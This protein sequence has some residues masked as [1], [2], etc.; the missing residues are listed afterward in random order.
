MDLPNDRY[1]DQLHRLK[2]EDEL[3]S[4]IAN[5]D[6]FFKK[7]FKRYYDIENI[8]QWKN[9]LLDIIK[10][11]FTTFP[12][13]PILGI[14]LI[15]DFDTNLYSSTNL[16]NT[17]M[18]DDTRKMELGKQVDYQINASSG[19]IRF[20]YYYKEEPMMNIIS[21]GVFMNEWMRYKNDIGFIQENVISQ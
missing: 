3:N 17:M 14:A 8:Q 16:Y 2:N 21:I 10:E 13:K 19:L 6:E 9:D 20:I 5:Y 12:Q 11:H 18:T 1:V 7:A 4:F 15:Y